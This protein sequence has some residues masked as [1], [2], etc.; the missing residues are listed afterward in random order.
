MFFV[1]HA[2]I[3][4]QKKKNGHF[5]SSINR[6]QQR[7]QSQKKKFIYSPASF[8]NQKSSSVARS[9]IL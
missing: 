5:L 9:K 8:I 7:G 2:E 1:D 4:L 3:D 6:S